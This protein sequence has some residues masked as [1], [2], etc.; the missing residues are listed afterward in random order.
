MYLGTINH[1]TRTQL[2]WKQTFIHI[3][4]N[5][6]DNNNEKPNSQHISRRI[7]EDSFIPYSEDKSLLWITTAQRWHWYVNTAWNT[8]GHCDEEESSTSLRLLR[9]NTVYSALKPSLLWVVFGSDVKCTHFFLYK[10]LLTQHPQTGVRMSGATL[11]KIKSSQSVWF[12]GKAEAKLKLSNWHVSQKWNQSVVAGWRGR[13]GRAK[14][15]A[16][17]RPFV[18]LRCVHSGLEET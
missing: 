11:K 3:Y 12:D 8:R 5:D 4:N 6:N 13:W 17:H 2:L 7:F 9:G 15:Q 1:T 18:C 14:T 16:S 10:L